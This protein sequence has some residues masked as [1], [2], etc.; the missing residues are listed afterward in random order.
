MPVGYIG[1]SANSPQGM[2]VAGR[3]LVYRPILVATLQLTPA[4]FQ[5]ESEVETGTA[6]PLLFPYSHDTLDHPAGW[7]PG[8]QAF[9]DTVPDWQHEMATPLPG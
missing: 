3:T 5:A 8:L 7:R 2:Q 6:S 9:L 1:P 4:V